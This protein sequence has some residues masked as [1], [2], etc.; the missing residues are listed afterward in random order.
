MKAFNKILLVS[1]ASLPLVHCGPS[2][3]DPLKNYQSYNTAVPAHPQKQIEQSAM[4]ALYYIDVQGDLTFVQGEENKVLFKTRLAF[5]NPNEVIYELRMVEGPSHLGARFEKVSDGVYALTWKPSTRILNPV[6]NFKSINLKIAFV[7]KPQSSAAVKS[8]FAGYQNV[9]DYEV[10]LMKDPAQPVIEDNIDVSP[11]LTLNP[12]QTATVRFIVAAKGLDSADSLTVN[13][14]GKPE[15]APSSELVQTDALSGISARPRRVKSLGQDA[16]GRQRYQYEFHFA[17]R[18]FTDHLLEQIQA[19]SRLKAKFAK[20]EISEGEAVVSIETVNA[21][22]GM[23]SAQKTLIMKVNLADKAGEPEFAGD[24]SIGMPSG[25]VVYKQ[26][27]VRSSDSRS[28]LSIASMVLGDQTVEMKNNKASIERD[29]LKIQLTCSRVSSTALK[30]AFG[31]SNGLCLESC[32]MKVESSCEGKDETVQVGL[33][34]KSTLGSDSKE[35]TLTYQINKRGKA[36]TCT[37]DTTSGGN[38]S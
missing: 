22:N 36:P 16:H 32:L 10:T 12:D 35:K 8:Q 7:L 4:T 31:C 13:L 20:G 17:A 34:A 3:K 15:N 29:D 25:S 18:P 38:P 37:A 21:Y 19:S 30:K 33:N 1:L 23:R 26:V 2:D 11:S 5:S 24:S 6:E 9:S 14:F 28:T 27:Y